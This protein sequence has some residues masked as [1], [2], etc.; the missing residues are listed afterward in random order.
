MAGGRTYWMP[1]FIYLFIL[2][3]DLNRFEGFRI[4]KLQELVDIQRSH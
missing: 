2:I 1:F 3:S 4:G